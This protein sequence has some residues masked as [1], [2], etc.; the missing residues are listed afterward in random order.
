MKASSFAKSQQLCHDV[1]QCAFQ[2]ATLIRTAQNAM[3]AGDYKSAADAM[4]S[5]ADWALK[6]KRAADGTAALRALAGSK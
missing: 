1:K 5:A 4:V 3:E 2:V 6:I